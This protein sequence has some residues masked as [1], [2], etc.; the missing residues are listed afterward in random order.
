M[1]GE[2]EVDNNKINLSNEMVNK[3]NN[4]YRNIFGHIVQTYENRI[5]A[6]S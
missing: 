1:H 4:I 3:K 2:Y 5:F 6:H